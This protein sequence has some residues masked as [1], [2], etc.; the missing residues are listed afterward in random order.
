LTSQV[1]T[2]RLST[3][4][5]ADLEQ[6]VDWTTAQFGA[7]QATAYMATLA[8]ALKALSGG[9]TVIGVRARAD[10]RA[11]FYT[12]HVARCR[13]RGRHFILFRIDREERETIVVLRILHDAMEL[14]RH[15]PPDASNE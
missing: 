1:W 6:I 15:L 9:P 14:A 8:D 12:L 3:A 11:N 5:K 7:A 10:I 2:V 13:R 4:A